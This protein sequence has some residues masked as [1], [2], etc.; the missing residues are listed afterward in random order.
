MA[1]TALACELMNIGT[2]ATNCTESFAGL[3]PYFLVALADDLTAAPEYDNTKAEF[4]ESSFAFATGK[5][6]YKIKVKPKSGKITSESNNGGKGFS[7]VYTGLVDKD[8]DNMSKVLRVMHNM[9]ILVMVPDGKGKHFVIYDP[10]F[11]P[12]MSSS[13]DTGDT[14]D[15]D[16]GHT[17]TITCNPSVYPLVKW[18]G[19][20]QMAGETGGAGG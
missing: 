12:E 17:V 14:P 15:S 10:L 13:S 19:T 18:S 7:N 6:F 5:G 4:T 2:S 20:P 3:P 9:D 11:T 1:G 16:S 8:M